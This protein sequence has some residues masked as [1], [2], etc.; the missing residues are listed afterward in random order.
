MC[1]GSGKT[2]EESQNNAASRALLLIADTGLENGNYGEN[3]GATNIDT[4]VTHSLSSI[5]E[6]SSKSCITSTTISS[7][8]NPSADTEISDIKKH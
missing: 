3:D 8:N 6:T 4:T 5:S 1:H 2:T 7:D